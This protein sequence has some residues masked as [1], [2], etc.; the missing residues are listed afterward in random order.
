MDSKEK[1]FLVQN[2]LLHCLCCSNS[3]LIRVA[4]LGYHPLAN[5][6]DKK[7]FPDKRK[8]PLELNFCEKCLN[9]Q[10]SI[11][12]PLNQNFK[13]Y[14]YKSSISNE[15]QL[16]FQKA[17][18][19]YIKRFKLKKNSHIVEIGSN[20]GIALLPFQRLKYKNITGIEPSK[21]LCK[22]SRAKGIKTINDF[23]NWKTAKK[24][25]SKAELVLASNVFAHS[26]S[27]MDMAKSMTQ[28]LKKNGTIIIEVQYLMDLLKKMSFDNIYHEH[29][30]Y[31]SLHSLIKFFEILNFKI[32][33]I[34]KINTHG[35]SIRVY[36]TSKY[37]IKYKISK[38][39]K[40][41]LLKEKKYLTKY[42]LQFQKRLDKMKDNFD[43]NV[44]VLNKKY[45]KIIGYGASAKAATIINFLN[46]EKLKMKFIADDN[47]L[48]QNKFIPCHNIKVVNKNNLPKADCAIVFSWNFF[49][50]IVKNN[51]NLATDFVSTKDLLTKKIL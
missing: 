16:H 34:E 28:I 48:K 20:D 13:N 31:W 7:Y 40:K 43:Y 1:N 23:F 5:D 50:E 27:L 22:E 3:S 11:S 47:T 6:L 45:K 19:K 46:F 8:Y 39:I 10:L 18:M 30:N 51:K 4:S 35:G 49:N 41:N 12:P 14:L 42:A 26:N 25:Q 15:F 17:A 38:N 44:N 36:V 2:Y 9:G 24:I 29:I 33:D 37:N 32:Y 21:I